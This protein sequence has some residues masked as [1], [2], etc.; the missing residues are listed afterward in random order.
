MAWNTDTDDFAAAVREFEQKLPGF[1]WSVGQC[2]IG[3]HASCA[4]DG[5]GDQAALLDGIKAGDPLD[6]GF[7]ADT[8]GGSPAEALRDVMM[9]ALA[10][11]RVSPTSKD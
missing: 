5:K 10:D 11:P 8:H 9:Q 1:W 3:A 4:V 6:S 7:H 2:S